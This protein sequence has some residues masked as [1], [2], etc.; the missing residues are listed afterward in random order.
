MATSVLE[1]AASAKQPGIASNILSTES[2]L[3]RVHGVSH[4]PLFSGLSA[5]EHREIASTARE[6]WCSAGETIF[7]QGD[8]VRHVYVVA[9]GVVKV[10]QITEEGKETL[11]RLESAGGLLDDVAGSE[12]LHSITAR[13]LQGCCLLVWEAARFE[14]FTRPSCT[15]HRNA[16]AI[17]RTR[18]KM[19][20]ER[21]CDV[22][23]RPVPQ[24]LARL[25]IHLAVKAPGS[26]APVELSREEL[27][28]MAGTSLYTVS[29]LLSAWADEDIVT[30]ER[31]TVVIEDLPRLLELTEPA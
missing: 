24:R 2:G 31:K 26:Y 20:Q 14:A 11:L 12:L 3:R 13:A 30:V 17:M 21:F 5:D 18:L 22:A 9:K 15:I 29:R 7:L 6:L 10:T 4:S 16:S 1:I 28:Q 25:V 19:L 23:T 8:P 27:A